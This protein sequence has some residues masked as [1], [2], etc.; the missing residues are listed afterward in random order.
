LTWHNHNLM[1]FINYL[2]KT[3]AIITNANVKQMTKVSAHVETRGWGNRYLIVKLS[4]FLLR[5]HF[6]LNQWQRGIIRSV[7]NVDLWL[8]SPNQCYIWSTVY[9]FVVWKYRITI[10]ESKKMLLPFLLLFPSKLV[11]K[12]VSCIKNNCSNHCCHF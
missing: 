4:Y 10:F 6:M 3:L 2:M 5:K 11:E 8:G 12:P 7:Y 9:V 1:C